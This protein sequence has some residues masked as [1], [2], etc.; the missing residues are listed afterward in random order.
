MLAG[1]AGFGELLISH[2]F[3]HHP[4]AGVEAF[5]YGGENASLTQALPETPLHVIGKAPDL[6]VFGFGYTDLAFGK[7]STEVASLLEQTLSLIILKTAAR[8]CIPFLVPGFF[9]G[10]PERVKCG[11]INRTVRGMA[12]QRVVPLDLE[13]AAQAFVDEHIHGSGEKHALHLD[14]ARLTPLG[15]LFLAHHAYRLIPWPDLDS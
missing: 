10:E 13:S 9:P 7:D 4:R 15:R 3:L 1:P 2:I 14:Y 11:D 12:S 6:V 8:I 5:I